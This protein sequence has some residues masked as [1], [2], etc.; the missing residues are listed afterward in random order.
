M[1]AKQE[2]KQRVLNQKLTFSGEQVVMQIHEQNES[3]LALHEK[4]HCTHDK[5]W[6][7]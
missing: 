5:G 2:E 4:E 3:A 7:K 1:L 6:L